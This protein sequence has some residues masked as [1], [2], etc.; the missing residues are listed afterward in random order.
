MPLWHRSILATA[1]V[2]MIVSTSGCRTSARMDRGAT[3]EVLATLPRGEQRREIEKIIG[4]EGEPLFTALID[5]DA[6]LAVQYSYL[7]PWNRYAF[8]YCQDRLR[9]I[10]QPPEYEYDRRPITEGEFAGSFVSVRRPV[11]LEPYLA[12]F[13]ESEDLAGEALLYAL[14]FDRDSE[15]RGKRGES[16]LGPIPYIFVPLTLP[17]LAISSPVWIADEIGAASFARKHDVRKAPL[18]GSASDA[19]RIYGSPHEVWRSDDRELRLY[20]EKPKIDE[21]GVREF[22]GVAIILDD[23]RITRVLGSRFLNGTHAADAGEWTRVQ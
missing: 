12:R 7:R 8:I 18:G 17:I 22:S 9:R 6:L 14:E 15:A 5:G 23:D 1:L 2:V 10:I 3:D 16:N 4:S 11:D 21:Y 13:L 20:G 19:D